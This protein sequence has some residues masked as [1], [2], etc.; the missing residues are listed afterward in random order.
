MDLQKRTK[1]EERLL[2]DYLKMKEYKKAY[3]HLLINH[4]DSFSKEQRERINEELNEIFKKNKDEI[5]N[6]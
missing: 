4:W 1:T 6:N 3:E 2:E 5:I